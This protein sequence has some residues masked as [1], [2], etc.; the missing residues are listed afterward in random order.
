MDI[1]DLQPRQGKVEVTGNVVSKESP[2]EIRKEN[3]NGSVCNVVLKDATAEVKVTLW[4]EQ[5]GQ[6]NVGDK[7]KISNGYVGEWQGEMQLSTG[8]FGSLEV[9]GKSEAAPEPS[10][11]EKPQMDEESVM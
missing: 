10:P 11:A 4:N 7:I 9:L 2:R 8:K 3:F 6:V 5:V 1:K